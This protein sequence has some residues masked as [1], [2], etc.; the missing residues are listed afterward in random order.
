MKLGVVG[1]GV[2]GR[3]TARAFIEHVDEVR[4]YDTVA[5][6]RTHSLADV[7]A[8]DLVMVCLPTPQKADSL[9]CDLSAVDSFFRV[10]SLNGHP[11]TSGLNLVLRSTVP[12]GTTRRL[13]EWYGLA[14]LVHSPEFL[15]ARVACTDAQL[16]AR[17]II[18]IP[19]PAPVLTEGGYNMVGTTLRDLYRRRFPG[20]PLHVMTSDESEAVKLF[21]NAFFA[22]KIATFNEFHTLATAMGLDWDA[23][24]AG[25]LSDGRI[26]HSHTKAPGPDGRFGFGGECLVKDLA[27][28]IQCM[29]AAGLG[30]RCHEEN[31]VSSAAYNRNEYD[32]Q[33]EA[34]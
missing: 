2:V 16:P 12:I 31:W 17:N 8:C 27:N 18:G 34:P 26:S 9:E 33:R 22:V 25:V 6:R 19:H 10:A 5:E 4:V 20:V 23:V 11:S 15:T 13:C 1:G 29:R 3:A 28:L 7:L 32:R 21:T 24:L 14:N 30:G